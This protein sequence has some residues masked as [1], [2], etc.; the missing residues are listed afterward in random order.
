MSRTLKQMLI[1]TLCSVGLVLG[2]CS[3]DGGPTE[4]TEDQQVV[5][6][7]DNFEAGTCFDKWT[8][9]GRRNGTS[10]ADCVTRNGSTKA[11]L[12]QD[13]S[14]TEVI[15]SPNVG[16]FAFRRDLTFEFELEV[17]TSTAGPKPDDTYYGMAEVRFVFLDSAGEILGQ[18]VHIAATTAHPDSW[19]SDPAVAVSWLAENVP[20]I[21][22]YKVGNLLQKIVIDENEIASVEMRFM[23]LNTTWCQPCVQAELWVDNVKVH[24][25][26]S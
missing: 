8:V 13:R 21:H 15:A 1:G 18:V 23:A 17:R 16:P 11:H 24:H 4:P 10:I 5:V 3:D 26:K 22:S 7:Q 12:L 25:P 19:A 6:F 20:T 2:A 14:H 9:G